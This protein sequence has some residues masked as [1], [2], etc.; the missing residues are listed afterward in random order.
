MNSLLIKGLKK[1]RRGDQ[2]SILFFSVH[3]SAST[4]IKKYRGLS[5]FKIK[6]LTTIDL[7]GFFIK[8]EAGRILQ[9]ILFAMKQISKKEKRIFLMVLFVLIIISRILI[10]TK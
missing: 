8:K 6:K 10:N 5:C 7:S 4:F 1:K 9:M 3:K 2:Q